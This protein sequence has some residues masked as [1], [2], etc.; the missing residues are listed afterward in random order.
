MFKVLMVI[1]VFE[2]VITIG[3]L[4]HEVC[5]VSARDKDVRWIFLSGSLPHKEK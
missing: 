3:V 1:S 5:D 4:A 2:I